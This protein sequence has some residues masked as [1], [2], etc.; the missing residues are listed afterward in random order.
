MRRVYYY[1]Y[2]LLATALLLWIVW[3]YTVVSDT[4]ESFQSAAAQPLTTLTQQQI[5]DIKQNFLSILSSTDPA[6]ARTI[7][8]VSDPDPN[9]KNDSY[10]LSF[11]K[12]ISIYSLAR[13]KT[14]SGSEYKDAWQM[15][16]AALFN[17]YNTLQT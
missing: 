6:M 3:T 7:A 13:A 10:P 1:I 2:T 16:R 11:S 17:N 8:S 4:K 14:I 12:Y 9:D 5:A 15:A